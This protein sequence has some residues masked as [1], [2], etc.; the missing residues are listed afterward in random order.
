MS[1]ENGSTKDSHRYPKNHVNSEEIDSWYSSQE[2][3][4]VGVEDVGKQTTIFTREDLFKINSVLPE[5]I[6]ELNT[7]RSEQEE[8]IRS[9]SNEDEN[10]LKQAAEKRI[11]KRNSQFDD[12]GLGH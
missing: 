7:L 3:Q 1:N 11:A 12:S 4:N 8:K 6:G 2:T 5:L 10:D 9:V